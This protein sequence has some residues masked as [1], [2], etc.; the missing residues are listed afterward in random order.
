MQDTGPV[1][2]SSR[3]PGRRSPE[4][5]PNKVVSLFQSCS[6]CRIESTWYLAWAVV[7]PRCGG[8]FLAGDQRIRA[9]EFPIRQA[10]RLSLCRIDD[11]GNA[12]SSEVPPI[13]VVSGSGSEDV[14]SN[15]TVRPGRGPARQRF[16]A[17]SGGRIN[18][19]K[20]NETKRNDRSRSAT[21]WSNSVAIL[22][23]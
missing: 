7:S 18:G 22:S 20:Q 6:V 10:W 3:L 12:A 8:P 11:R 21:R 5:P 14:V 4:G 16:E 13:P 19:Q 23:L 2:L 15:P 9:L 17:S 1:L